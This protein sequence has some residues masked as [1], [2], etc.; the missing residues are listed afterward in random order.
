MDYLVKREK[1]RRLASSRTNIILKRLK[2]LGN[3]AN[4]STY[5]YTEDEIN[6]IFAEIE[7]QIRNTKANFYF[8]KEKKE[9]KL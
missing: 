6:K 3:C 1:F 5:A 2:I 8:P 7:R 9:F 4:R